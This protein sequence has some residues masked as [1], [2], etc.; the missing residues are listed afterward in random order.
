[1]VVVSVCSLKGG[2]G[3]TSLVLG[4]AAAALTRGMATL[5]VDLDPQGDATYALGVEPGDVVS[6][7]V[8]ERPKRKLLERA[9]ASS[10]WDAEGGGLVHVL[11]SSESTAAVDRPDAS[12]EQLHTLRHALGKLDYDLVLVD[13]PPSLSALTRSALVAS[14]RA[15]IV[16]EPGVFAANAVRRLLGAIDEL[17]RGE[18]GGLQPLGI[19]VNRY[20]A[21]LSE[22][23]DQLE[24]L[25]R[26]YGPL[27]LRPVVHER[28]AMQK[29]QGAR[30][31]LGSA[32]GEQAQLDVFDAILE[33]AM[34]A[35]RRAEAGRGTRPMS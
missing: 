19:V 24:A 15:I 13:A 1:M 10:T 3:K 23:R 17:R 32:R 6:G 25:E 29:A 20:K 2:V 30:R 14:D 28:S 26:T 11:P 5:V 16:T 33:R 12:G 35:G 4:L 7:D 34:R 18:A 21:G 8:I 27:V 9:I 31:P 22:Q